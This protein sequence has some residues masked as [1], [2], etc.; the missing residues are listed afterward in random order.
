M[1]NRFLLAITHFHY[2]NTHFVKVRQTFL[3]NHKILKTFRL[4]CNYQVNTTGIIW[5]FKIKSF[6]PDYVFQITNFAE[7]ETT[8]LA[9]SALKSPIRVILSYFDVKTSRSLP[10]SFK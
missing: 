9:S 7:S 1:N 10:I 2:R 3:N 4:V 8:V 6:P 5:I